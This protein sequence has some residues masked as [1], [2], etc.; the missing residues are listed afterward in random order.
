VWKSSDGGA[1]WQPPAPNN[2]MA[3]AESVWSL[4]SYKIDGPLHQEKAPWMR[5]PAV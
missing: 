5:D 1:T 4:G 2:G 3:R